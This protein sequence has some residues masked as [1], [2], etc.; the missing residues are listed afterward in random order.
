MT[1]LGHLLSSVEDNVE[2]A[3]AGATTAPDRLERTRRAVRRRRVLRH[4][5]DGAAGAVVLV[6]VVGLTT[7]GVHGRGTVPADVATPPTSAATPTVDAAP[8]PT[9]AGEQLVVGTPVPAATPRDVPVADLL[10]RTGPGWSL[11]VVSQQRLDAP[12]V[13]R[14]GDMRDVVTLVSPTGERT[15]LLD[16]PERTTLVLHDWR[17]GTSTAVASVAVGPGGFGS[18][19]V[20]LV[21]GTVAP[22][23]FAFE[24]HP[25]GLTATGESA[26]L[27]VPLSDDVREAV[28]A[29]PGRLTPVAPGTGV[30][31]DPESTV[32]PEG[33][34]TPPTSGP[35]GRLRL[36]SSD[37]V[38]RDA[39]DVTLPLRLHPLSPD[40]AWLAVQTPDG[41]L[42]GV[43]LR[44]GQAHPVAGVE[45]GC[46]LV[47]WA[48]EHAVLTACPEGDGE[49]RLVAVD[50][51]DG[52]ARPRALAT[53]DTPV[54]DAW[55][56][57]DGRIGLG[58]VVQPAP[59]DVTSDPAVLADGRVRSLTDGWSPYDHGT[60]LLFTGGAVWTHL[61]GCYPG[62]GRADPQRDVRVDLAT[63][64]I[65]TLA[66]LDDRRDADHVVVDEDVWLVTQVRLTPG[67]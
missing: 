9:P 22:L 50:V 48:D 60:D 55:P 32:D 64:A 2:R 38:A 17:P 21:T 52:A 29:E 49:W 40:R 30:A 59:C 57:G 26:W 39:G 28:A 33:T 56:L 51:A 16:V 58:R 6:V 66:W 25:L 67:R 8:A 19:L 45:D 18:G 5:R 34:L 4:T 31:L 15:A 35:T 24:H 11:A 10:A 42:Q 46:R 23:P 13:M 47:G 54:R 3:L 65:T 12:D 61:N 36:V 53:T 44:T 20:D 1:D 27:D 43:D 7:W 63:G 62:S 37:G 41:A 14:P